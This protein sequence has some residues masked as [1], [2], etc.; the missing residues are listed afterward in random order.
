MTWKGIRPM[1]NL[2]EKTYEKGVR[3]TKKGMK[4]Y[5]RRIKRS[6]R[7]SKWDVII[8]PVTVPCQI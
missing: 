7:L 5:E 1:V 3:L 6:T 4:A 2:W 8:E